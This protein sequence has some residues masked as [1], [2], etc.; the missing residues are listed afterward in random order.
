MT[1]FI[2]IIEVKCD[3]KIDKIKWNLYIELSV[4]GH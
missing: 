4:G 2:I 1:V 3:L